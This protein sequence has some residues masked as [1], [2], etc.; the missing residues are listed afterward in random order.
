MNHVSESLEPR[1]PTASFPDSWACV[2]PGVN[3][4]EARDA[5]NELQEKEVSYCDSFCLI[6]K[7]DSGSFIISRGSFIEANPSSESNFPECL[8]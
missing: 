7:P 8:E 1:D 3:C 5:L 4:K 6:M 2:I